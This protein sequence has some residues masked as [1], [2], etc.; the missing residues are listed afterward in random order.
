LEGSKKRGDFRRGSFVCLSGE[1]G[2]VANLGNLKKGF[3]AKRGKKRLI[4]PA[5]QGSGM[6]G[7]VKNRKNK[8]EYSMIRPLLAS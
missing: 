7:N 3:S 5:K 8:S 2:W 1:I 4:S 6:K